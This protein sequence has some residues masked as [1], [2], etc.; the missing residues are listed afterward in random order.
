M[1]D[2]LNYEAASQTDL[3]RFEQIEQSIYQPDNKYHGKS[4]AEILAE[5]VSA[6]KEDFIAQGYEVSHN[7]CF[8]PDGSRIIF[9]NDGQISHILPRMLPLSEY[10]GVHD[11][12]GL[13]IYSNGHDLVFG[14]APSAGDLAISRA[15]KLKQM[16]EN[17]NFTRIETE[18]NADAWFYWHCYAF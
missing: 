9:T 11:A 15:E 2:R 5:C 14:I 17:G 10:N 6:F 16:A 7:Y 3:P 8:L 18:R 1:E 4:Y 13:S 12:F